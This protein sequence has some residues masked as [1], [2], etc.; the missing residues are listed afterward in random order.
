[1]SMPRAEEVQR[2]RSELFSACYKGDTAK[3]DELLSG[4]NLSVEYFK[5][6]VEP[7]KELCSD[8]R[9]ISSM[10]LVNKREA[11]LLHYASWR[12]HAAL[13]RRVHEKYPGLVSMKDNNGVTALHCAAAAGHR[14]CIE[15]LHNLD[16]EIGRVQVSGAT[17]LHWAAAAG[18][19]ECIELLHNLDPELI[20]MKDNHGATALNHAAFGGRRECIELLHRLDP[21]LIRMKG[22][23]GATALHCAAERDQKECIETLHKLDP[24]LIRM[25]D[26]HGATALNYA[27]AKG[28]REC[29]E[30]LHRLDPE[31]IRMKDNNGATALHCAA[32]MGH[33]EC[34]ELLHRLDSELIR[35][36]TNNGAT[37]LH[38]AAERGQKEC[39]E[40]LDRLDSELIRM[41][42][43]NGATA[44]HRAAERG[45]KQC[46]E[47]LHRL[48]PELIRMK[49][50]NRATALN[51]AAAKGHRECIELLHRLDPQL[52]RVKMNSGMTALHWAAVNGHRGCI[53]LL[54]ALDQELIRRQDNNG[55]TALHHAA[56]RGQDASVAWLCRQSY[57][58]NSVNY[59][60][61]TPLV[62][63]IRARKA[64]VIELLLDAGSDITF[65]HALGRNAFYYCALSC[66][67]EL[68]TILLRRA[69]K[70]F[71]PVASVVEQAGMRLRVSERVLS[72]FSIINYPLAWT[73]LSEPLREDCILMLQGKLILGKPILKKDIFLEMAKEYTA[74]FLTDEFVSEFERILGRP[75][76]TQQQREFISSL[77]LRRDEMKETIL[78]GIVE[79]YR[80]LL[81]GNEA[82]SDINAEEISDQHKRRRLG[83]DASNVPCA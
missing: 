51:H 26:N 79:R 39:I 75:E 46:I 5:G 72:K 25:K 24:E 31:L 58:I 1:M 6:P 14:E 81:V 49:D 34:V 53:E 60:G 59:N 29:I 33:R 32:G 48:D 8:N 13:I 69:Y 44:L 19:R 70:L 63:A 7:L 43:N 9:Y 74:D 47:L 21:E 80:E 10:A 62:V 16:P 40:T 55:F 77:L 38:C 56:D 18:H 64:K 3:I 76:L 78:K 37:A 50:N 52:I 22:N 54:H 82:G 41:K 28:H 27:A 4:E 57:G 15:L 42:S 66:D 71:R 67:E 61:H 45:H 17:A 83:E 11:S 35:M 2:V 20:R 23:N 12:G 68:V 73:F 30:L 65:E 36:K